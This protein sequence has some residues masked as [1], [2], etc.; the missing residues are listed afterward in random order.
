[1][2]S[3]EKRERISFGEFIN[4]MAFMVVVCSVIYGTVLKDCVK[5]T[6]K[7]KKESK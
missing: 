3:K 4:N 1:M 6:L 7:R 2:H 5:S